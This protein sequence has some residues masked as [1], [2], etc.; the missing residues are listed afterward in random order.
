MLP[1]AQAIPAMSLAALPVDGWLAPERLRLLLPLLLAVAFALRPRR[2]PRAVSALALTLAA[3]LLVAALAQPIERSGGERAMRWVVLV[4]G[5]DSLGA[6]ERGRRDALLAEVRGRLAASPPE[7]IVFGEGEPEPTR[8]GPALLAARGFDRA[9]LIGD[10]RAAEPPS[11]LAALAAG[12][13]PI[14][15][16]AHLPAPSRRCL[17]DQLEIARAPEANRGG[18]WQLAYRADAT[19]DARLKVTLHKLGGTRVTLHQESLVLVAGPGTRSGNLPKLPAGRYQLLAELVPAARP[20][21]EAPVPS[22]RSIALSVGESARLLV[23]SERAD[24]EPVRLLEATRHKIDV[25]APEALPTSLRAYRR[26][27]AVVLAGVPLS[28]I[29]R[30]ASWAIARYLRD[31]GGGLLLLEGLDPLTA[32]DWRASP[33]ANHFPLEP[34]ADPRP[35]KEDLE[36]PKRVIKRPPRKAR[37]AKPVLALVLLIDCSASMKEERK[38]LLAR[39]AAI[40]SARQLHARDLIGVIAFNDSPS[41]VVRISEARNRAQIEADINQLDASGDTDIGA[42]LKAAGGKLRGLKVPV[43]HVVLLTDGHTRPTTFKPLVAEMTRANITLSTIGIGRDFDATLLKNLAA[44]G[45]GAYTVSTSPDDIAELVVREARGALQRALVHR[46]KDSER[47]IPDDLPEVDPERPDKGKQPDEGEDN[48]EPTPGQSRVLMLHRAAALA[49]LSGRLPA[50]GPAARTRPRPGATVLLAREA[51]RL[52][53]LASWRLGRGKCAAF[54][55]NVTDARSPWSRWKHTPRLVAQLV[56]ELLADEVPTQ[57]ALELRP[58]WRPD[59]RLQLD[60][61]AEE[62]DGRPLQSPLTIHDAETQLELAPIQQLAPGWF[63]LTTRVSG[64]P[65]WRIQ[66]GASDQLYAPPP[67]PPRPPSAQAR[68]TLTAIA[69]ASGG[70][71][72]VVATDLQAA[73]LPT[74]PDER[75]LDTSLLLALALCALAFGAASW[76]VTP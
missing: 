66:A 60:V 23:V 67:A 24:S 11:A 70:R 6:E 17:I 41:W 35:P 3:A 69:S 22:M 43:K 29:G 15:V 48:P 20:G 71:P 45:K 47:E 32:G 28:R 72:A 33:L 55:A 12:G 16:A 65:L 49:G 19:I 34:L 50:I 75:P 36:P 31:H 46:D 63:R 58:S 9:L 7:V 37:V 2:L 5:S 53:I 1:A 4:D 52:P 74:K 27:R 26:Y 39:A 64:A 59:G 51:D 8:Y 62:G 73:P 56:G 10:G 18:R 57:S 38:L 68:A 13:P 54:A 25:L 40:A 14:D 30:R 42:A 44:W 21:L 61:W 76:R